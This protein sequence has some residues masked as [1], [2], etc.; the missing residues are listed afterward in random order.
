MIGDF[1]TIIRKFGNK[2]RYK[3]LCHDDYKKPEKIFLDEQSCYKGVKFI[4]N[5]ITSLLR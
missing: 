5:S 3:S 1:D 2:V 4:P